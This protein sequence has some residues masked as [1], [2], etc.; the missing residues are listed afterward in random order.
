MLFFLL[1]LAISLSKH[2]NI[3][4]R[5]DNLPTFLGMNK[6]LFEIILLLCVILLTSITTAFVGSINFCWFF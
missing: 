3:W 1:L 4:V 2:L 5:G 6:R